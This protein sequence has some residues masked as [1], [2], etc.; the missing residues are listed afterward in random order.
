MVSIRRQDIDW[1]EVVHSIGSKT[2]L[3]MIPACFINPGDYVLMT[4]PGY[5]VLGTH[6]KYLGGRSITCLS[7]ETTSSPTSTP[8]RAR[9]QQDHGAQLPEQPDRRLRDPRVLRK[10]IAFAKVNNLI[11]LQ[12]AVYASLIFEG[13]PSSIFKLEAP[14]TSRSNYSL[15]VYN[16]TGWRIGFVV[17]TRSSSKP[18]AT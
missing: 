8:S 9:S 1:G 16:M 13:E 11:I 15:S 18:T 10:A 5:P 4:V 7:A 12:D 6:A 2:A 17:G 3:S 14:R